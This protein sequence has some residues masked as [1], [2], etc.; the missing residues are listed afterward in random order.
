MNRLEVARA[1][2]AAGVLGLC[3]G[4]AHAQIAVSANDG[5]QPRL[6]EQPVPADFKPDTVSV[7]DL[8]HYP[9]KVI[10]A[11]QAPVSMIGPPT[12]V[13]VARDGSFAI[14]TQSQKYDTSVPPKVVLDG[15]VSVIDL[16]DPRRP[17]VVQ[18]LTAGPGAT[19]VAINRAQTLA[20]IAATGDGSVTVYSIAGKRL[21]Q[22]GKVQLDPQP[23]PVDVAISPDGKTALVTQRRGNGV[24]R[25]AIAGTR[26]T[27]AGVSYTTGE[28][29][30]GAAF[31]PDSAWGYTSALLGNPVP[32]SGAAQAGP[33][34]GSARIGTVSAIDLRRNVVANTI[35]VG[36]TPEHL[37]MSPD[38][39]Y[40]AVTV[41]NGS[42]ADPTTANYNPYGLLKVY[43]AEGAKLTQ[44]AEARTGSWGQGA[45]WAD[46]GRVILQQGAINKEIEVY[47]FDG[48]SLTRDPA[49]T[50][51]FDARPG[52]IMT[53]HSR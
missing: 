37:A 13:G 39:R 29:T 22:V 36:P 44:V 43:R 53:Q 48:K 28:Q 32:P 30:Y 19:G 26:V 23:G 2:L 41:V 52:A 8:N 4:A 1:A 9:P 17:A 10:G 3:G 6:Y 46:N 16:K 40:L 33:G 15:T 12:S 31:S 7:I 11:V 34:G 21:T 49:A 14:V 5:E 47:R 20:L 27:N 50:L 18:T 25:L 51:K 42:S 45:A 24:W 38:G 35:E